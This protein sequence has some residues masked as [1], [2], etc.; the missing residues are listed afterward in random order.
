[1]LSS[2]ISRDIVKCLG[3]NLYLLGYSG[4]PESIIL[5]S[6]KIIEIFEPFSAQVI[7]DIM[8]DFMC[9]DRKFKYSFTIVD[10]CEALKS[11]GVQTKKQAEALKIKDDFYKFQEENR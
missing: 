10:I 3:E 7:N 1:M 8:N 9:G 2:E 5:M 4:P 11:V 6:S